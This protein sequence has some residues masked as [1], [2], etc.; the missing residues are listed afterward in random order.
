MIL[1]ALIE[2]SKIILLLLILG[3][4]KEILKLLKNKEK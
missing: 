4:T 2:G 3:T 1:G